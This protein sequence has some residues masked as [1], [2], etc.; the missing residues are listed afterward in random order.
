VPSSPL[1]AIT[2]TG[3]ASF[4]GR[5]SEAIQDYLRAVTVR[6]SMAEAHA[7]LASAYKDS[8]L[9]EAAIQSY[10]HALML[11]PSFPEAFCNL[12]HTLQCVCDW[13]DRENQFVQL[14]KVIRQQIEVGLRMSFSMMLYC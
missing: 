14:E 5:V 1:D 3:F 12:L 10:R 6:P 2:N 4:Q 8:G 13:D 11:R 7:N 9:S